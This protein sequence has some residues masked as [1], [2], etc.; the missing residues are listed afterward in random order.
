MCCSGL[1]VQS[2]ATC[3]HKPAETRSAATSPVQPRAPARRK[4]CRPRA[5]RSDPLAA[6]KDPRHET[7]DAAAGLGVVRG[8]L[9]EDQPQGQEVK[10]P[11]SKPRR[12]CGKAQLDQV[13]DHDDHADRDQGE[14]A[15]GTSGHRNE[16]IPDA[17]NQYRQALPANQEAAIL[18]FSLVASRKTA[19][20]GYC[21]QPAP[22]RRQ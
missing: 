20:D 11:D 18:R 17:V 14:F 12:Y 3:L 13:V 22:R 19:C 7:V 2:V 21:S 1:G 10:H 4:Q 8:K 5:S 16:S 9:G 15:L 6:H